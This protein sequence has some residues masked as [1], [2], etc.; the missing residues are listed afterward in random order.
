M[1]HISHKVLRV[2][3]HEF[4]DET[5]GKLKIVGDEYSVGESLEVLNPAKHLELFS[6]FLED[7][8]Q[9]RVLFI[10]AEGEFYDEEPC[11]H[12]ERDHGVCCE[13]GVQCDYDPRKEID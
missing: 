9:D 10:D 2:M 3:F 8:V 6:K 11:T 12:E 5:W 4:L 13:C 1:K 7:Q